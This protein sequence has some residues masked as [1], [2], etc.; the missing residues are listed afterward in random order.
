MNA[1]GGNP[2]W[3]S[4]MLL[5]EGLYEGNTNQIGFPIGVYMQVAM[6]VHCMWNQLPT[7]GDLSGSLTGIRQ[8]PDELFQDFVDRLLKTASRIFGDFQAEN[9]LVTQLAY[10]NAN[11]ACREAIRPHRGKNRLSWFL[12]PKSGP[13]T[14]KV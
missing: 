8:V 11:A 3:D 5:G 9:P 6:A 2:D 4:E 10:E 7:K 13:R 1:Q 14:I 12:V